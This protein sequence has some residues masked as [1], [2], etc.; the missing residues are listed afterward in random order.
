MAPGDGGGRGRSFAPPT[1]GDAPPPVGLWAVAGAVVLCA[2][3]AAAG[4]ECGVGGGGG[5][6]GTGAAAAGLLAQ[7]QGRP[8]RNISGPAGLAAA[9]DAGA[10]G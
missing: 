1:A 10:A 4:G 7:R 2:V 5:S 9:A 8:E 3:A 6:G